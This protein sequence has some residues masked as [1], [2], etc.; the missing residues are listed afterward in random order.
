MGYSRGMLETIPKT[1]G[2]VMTR[3]VV[4]VTEQQTLHDAEVGMK[5]FHFR[6]LPVVEGDKLIGVVT[7]RDLLHASSSWLSDK[8]E[9]RDEIIHKLPVAEIMRREVV[10]VKASDPLLDAA[11]LLWEGKLGCLPVTG[12]D[13]A[14]VGMLTEADFVK[15]AIRMLSDGPP[16]PPSSIPPGAE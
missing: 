10:T 15:L 13:G 7:Q 14:L 6:H 8:A 16:P 2:E 11:R 9:E 1:V 3:Q 4:T 12:D 5:Q